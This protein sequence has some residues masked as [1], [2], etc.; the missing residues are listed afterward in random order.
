MRTLVLASL[1]LLA[2]PTIAEDIVL[3]K[4]VEPTCYTVGHDQYGLPLNIPGYAT[5]R[6]STDGHVY[7][8]NCDFMG[9]H[10]AGGLSDIG[11]PTDGF[12]NN[13][14]RAATKL[15]NAKLLSNGM[16]SLR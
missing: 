7:E 15:E 3:Q 11:M 4:S 5:V 2:S 12:L 16:I 13:A 14:S 10:L 1:A 8:R 9:D 6:R